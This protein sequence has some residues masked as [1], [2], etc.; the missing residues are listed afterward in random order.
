MHERTNYLEYIGY[1]TTKKDR[2]LN[3]AGLMLY[4]STPEEASELSLDIAKAIRCD[5]VQLKCG[6]YLLIS[7][8]K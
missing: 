1:V 7:V 3:G 5:V 2:V 4:A 6:D 8:P